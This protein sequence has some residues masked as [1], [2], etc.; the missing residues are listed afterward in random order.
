MAASGTGRP[1]SPPSTSANRELD[2]AYGRASSGGAAGVPDAPR[3][4]QPR[5]AAARSDGT[6]VVA[7]VPWTQ[8]GNGNRM[9]SLESVALPR[10]PTHTGEADVREAGGLGDPKRR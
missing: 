5:K 9:N 10:T 3:A 8:E 4:Q 1:S 2:S 6:Q 7:S